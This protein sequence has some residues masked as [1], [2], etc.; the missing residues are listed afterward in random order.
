MT[1]EVYVRI[2]DFFESLAKEKSAKPH[3]I[4]VAFRNSLLYGNLHA[5]SGRSL[6]QNG[7]LDNERHQKLMDVI[8]SLGVVSSKLAEID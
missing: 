1:Q 7:K 3:E 2:Q 5:L 4:L 6:I 8:G